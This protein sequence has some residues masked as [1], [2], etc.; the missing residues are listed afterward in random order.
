MHF[1]RKHL[2]I[3][4]C[5][6]FKRSP[7]VPLLNLPTQALKTALWSTSTSDLAKLHHSRE[8]EIQIHYLT[9]KNDVAEN[10][11]KKIHQ[12]HKTN[13]LIW[14]LKMLDLFQRMYHSSIL[15]SLSPL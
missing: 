3:V 6:L 1:Y 5:R 15:Q 13:I 14:D 8:S 10:V 7:N 4:W 9:F 2:S 11:K 12:Q